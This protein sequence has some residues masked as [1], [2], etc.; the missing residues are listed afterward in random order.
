MRS[1][2]DWQLFEGLPV[3]GIIRHVGEDVWPEILKRYVRSG[4]SS[5]EVT[6]NT[7]GAAN[8]IT[9]GRE[10]FG[11][12]LNI[13][14]GTVCTMHD[15]TVALEAGA[16]FIVTPVIVKDVIEACV[17]MGVPVFPGAFTPSEIFQAW[18]MGASMVKVF[19]SAVLGPAYIKAVKAPFPHIKLMPTGGIG[20]KD[21]AAYKQAGADAFGIGSPLFPEELITQRDWPGLEKHFKSFL[22]NLEEAHDQ[23]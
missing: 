8:M 4:F 3:V 23:A 18:S 14:A 19:P 13:G 15:L 16:G 2:F 6:M 22:E 11:K 1:A 10:H 20:G 9:W 12:D 5:I 21:I 7:P 17:R